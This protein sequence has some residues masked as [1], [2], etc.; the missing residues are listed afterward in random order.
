VSG[1]EFAIVLM[2]GAA[3]LALW[4]LWRYASFGPKTLFWALA[5][6]VVACVLLRFLP[7][8]FPDHDSAAVSVRL[9]VEVFALALPALVYAFLSG[10]WLTRIAIRQ[11]RP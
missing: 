6:V 4:I 5:H 9:Y 10:G 2:V 8:V 3:V 1:Q 11:L 7:L